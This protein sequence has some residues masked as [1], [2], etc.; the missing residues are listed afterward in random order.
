MRYIRNMNCFGEHVEAQKKLW[1]SHVLVAGCGGLGGYVIE[2]LARAGIG[3]FTICD[4]DRF[5]ESNLNRQLYSL[6][7]NLGEF[8]SLEAKKRILEINQDIKVV[9]HCEKFKA[10]YLENIDV[11]L[12]CLGGAE[13]RLN[14]QECAHQLNI[15]V[16]SAGISGWSALVSSAYP[17]EKGLADFMQ[18]TVDNK[19]EPSE[20]IEGSPV[21]SVMFAASLQ[22]AEALQLLTLDKVALKDKILLA[23]IKEG[24]FNTMMKS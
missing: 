6:P 1:N 11:V 23:N 22:I 9:A 19:K 15:P 17:K 7:S 13:N 10:E 20:N 3:S 4:H 8:K 21:F 5:E 16:I 24:R 12:D 18:K 2:G 14:L